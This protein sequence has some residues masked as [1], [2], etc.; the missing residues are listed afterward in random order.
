MGV[1][2]RMILLGF[3][4]REKHGASLQVV[5]LH[6]DELVVEDLVALCCRR[7]HILKRSK[8]LPTCT[9]F[10]GVE[11]DRE[12]SCDGEDGRVSWVR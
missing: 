5:G 8:C 10:H 7:P 1:E 4:G 3:L 12:L 2:A 6:R 9:A 11:S